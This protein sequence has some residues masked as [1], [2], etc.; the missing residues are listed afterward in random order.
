M[1]ADRLMCSR[2]LELLNDISSAILKKRDRNEVLNESIEMIAD[3]FNARAGSVALPDDDGEYFK[4]IAGFNREPELIERLNSTHRLQLDEGVAGHAFSERR[5]V[6]VEDIFES[7]IFE[8]SFYEHAERENFRAIISV[9]MVAYG[10]CLGVV[11]LYY[12]QTRTFDDILK[13]TLDSATNQVALALLQADMFEQLEKSNKKLKILSET[14]ELTGLLNHRATRNRLSDALAEACDHDNCFS[15]I[16]ADIDHFK[17]INDQH[18]HPFGDRVLE[19][20]GE[21]FKHEIDT[22]H[23]VG[24]DGGEEFLIGLTQTCLDEAISRAENLREAVKGMSLGREDESITITLSFGVAS[25]DGSPDSLKKLIK[26]ADD[27]LY[28]AKQAGR[29][30]VVSEKK[31]TEEKINQ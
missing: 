10:E 30:R 23:V 3:T 28:Q 5:I 25:R 12:E 22:R 1:D 18:G 9:P 31:L 29:N 6:A 16:M 2:A 14:D 11:S 4:Y 13:Q 15:V 26:I 24:R 19:Q 21:L 27:A 20:I 7:D 8:P 17:Q